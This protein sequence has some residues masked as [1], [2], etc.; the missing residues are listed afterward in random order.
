MDCNW[1][2]VA[3]RSLEPATPEQQ[4]KCGR[5]V[6]RL[7][8]DL[9]RSILSSSSTSRRNAGSLFSTMSQTSRS[10]ISAYPWMRIL[11]QGTDSPYGLKFYLWRLLRGFIG[12]ERRPNF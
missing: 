8:A 4:L 7:R 2:D 1:E 12:A 10:S 5:C 3:E 11:A 9:A 6:R